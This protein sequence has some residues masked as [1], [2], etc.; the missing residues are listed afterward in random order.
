MESEHPFTLQQELDAGIELEAIF[1]GGKV[2]LL[3]FDSETAMKPIH[4]IARDTG[5]LL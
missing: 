4:R 1:D 3:I 2:D 5:L